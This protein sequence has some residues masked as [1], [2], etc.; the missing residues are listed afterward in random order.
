[1]TRRAVPM[2][3]AA[4]A[5]AAA[6]PQSAG[7]DTSA[8]PR[9]TTPGALTIVVDARRG[10]DSSPG[11][12]RRPLRTVAA[13]WAR[14]PQARPLDRAVRV[15]VRPGRYTARSL[16]NYWESRWGTR[17]APISIV[18]ARRG[19]VRFGA[20]NLY[21]LRWVAFSGIA[22]G[23]RFDLFHCEAC[24]HVLLT[25]SRLVGSPTELH[26]NVKVNQST[27][28]AITHSTISGAGDNT[29]DFVAVQNAR[30]ADN[31]IERAGDWCAY[32]KGGS[33]NVLV[34]RNRIRRCG[35]GGFTAGQGTGLQFMVPPFVR[36]EAEA[37]D[38]LDNRISDVEG[39][40][41][42]V[43]GGHDVVIARNRMWNV[44][45]RSHWV[46]VGYG[47]R[48]C[49]GQPGDEGRE[50]CQ[51]NLD[52]GGWGTTRVDDGTN[53]VRIPNR[54]VWIAGNV[55]D[56]PRRQGDQL[57]SVA[58]PFD[59]PEAQAGSGLGP[60]RA[61]D[62]LH[63]AGNLIAGRGLPAGVDECEA[64]DCRELAARNSLSA[65]PGLFVAPERGDL[66]LRPGV[67]APA[68]ALPR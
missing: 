49:D 60:V 1:M 46:E 41:V 57:F 24:Q 27:D 66:R 37:V 8:V 6:L 38:V 16:P 56:N 25:R 23:D 40:G 26:E 62:D 54:S 51:Q 29:I 53:Y 11:T 34:A 3:L 30:I 12:S 67:T 2:L 47:G 32:A 45:S 20:V 55:I 5:I 61:D 10:R 14:I 59:D 35:V 9:V 42:G 63:V 65:A 7:A 22:F 15:L 68:P 17:A 43:N 39:A 44:G 50:R 28:V 36:Y 31:T 58:G 4:A 13:A 48:S 33:A 52:A 64:E 18:A 19:T 21:D